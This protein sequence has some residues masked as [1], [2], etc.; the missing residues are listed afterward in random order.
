MLSRKSY[1]VVAGLAGGAL[2]VLL[3]VI[4]Y[5][6]LTG[7][8]RAAQAQSDT[9]HSAPRSAPLAS[10]PKPVSTV[11]P[12]L[13]DLRHTTSQPAHVEPYEQTDVYAKASGFVAKVLVDIGDRVEKDQVLAELWV[14]EMEQDRLQNAAVVEEARSAIAQSKAKVRAADAM[15]DA[16]SAK[17]REAQAKI[18]QHDAEVAFRRSEHAR[19]VRL[20]ADSA[21]NG[22]L[23]DEKL[24]QLRSAEATLYAAKASIDS[25]DADVK[26]EQAK[27]FQAQAELAN[28]EARLKV[29]EAKLRHSEILL[30]YR[31]VRA[32]YAAIVTRRLVDTGFFVTS[33]SSTKTE[34]LFTVARVDTLRVVADI[35]ESESSLVRVGQPVSLVVD[36][37][38]GRSFNGVVKRTAG[39]LDAKSRTLRIEAELNSSPAELRPGM[40]GVVSVILAD[41]KG[42]LLVPS[43]CIRY[44]DGK[45]AVLCVVDGQVIRRAVDIGYSDA[46]RTEVTA[47]LGPEDQVIV[48]NIGEARVG[49]RVRTASAH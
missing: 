4:L 15:V 29:A 24:N 6:Y 20:S 45:P 46:I 28:T 37:L 44:D 43:Q 41:Q 10:A 7:A 2:L 40:F 21:L 9:A 25:A 31:Q 17:F 1:R 27:Q 8:N 42:A 19:F 36:A 35:P 13:D 11:R 32:P 48:G 30:A 38:K 34:P 22:S 39:V 16:A 26:V 5:P 12:T 3:V 47:G 18:A 49:Q 23:V 14:P 33:P